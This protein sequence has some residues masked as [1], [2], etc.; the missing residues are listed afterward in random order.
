MK[1][2]SPSSRRKKGGAPKTRLLLLL[3]LVVVV[4]LGSV[5]E[6]RVLVLPFSVPVLRARVVPLLDARPPSSWCD[7]VWSDAA[8]RGAGSWEL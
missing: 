1:G 5:I 7:A 8:R 3:F 4:V 2:L 6:V